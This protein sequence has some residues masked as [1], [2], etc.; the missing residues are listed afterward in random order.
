MTLQG[1]SQRIL[2]VTL[3]IFLALAGYPVAAQ[4]PTSGAITGTVKDPSGAVV[5]GAKVTATLTATGGTRQVETDVHGAFRIPL[6][7]PGRY[8][9]AAK[10]IF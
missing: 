10:V 3:S 7:P 4:T 8:Q 9:P 6:L 5:V 2:W 1:L